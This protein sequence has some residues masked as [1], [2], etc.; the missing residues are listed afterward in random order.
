MSNK[1]NL[2]NNLKTSWTKFSAVQVI[3]VISNNEIEDYLIGKK[4]IDE[5]ILKSFLGIKDLKDPI[6]YY[7]KEI[8]K[9]PS[10]KK[11]FALL[12]AIFTHHAVIKEFAESSSNETFGG[13]LKIQEGVKQ[14]TNLRRA[15]IESG[16]SD[17]NNGRK[18]IVPYNFSAIY[19]VGGLGKL[20]KEVLKERLK[21]I[22]Y[23]NTENNSEFYSLAFELDFHKVLCLNK[24]QFKNW[25]EGDELVMKEIPKTVNLSQ[26]ENLK[27]TKALVVKQ[28]MNE[29]DK[30]AFDETKKRKKPAS[31]FLLLSI[32]AQ[33]LKK[34]SDVKRR[35]VKDK[36]ID[37]LGIQRKLT[38]ERSEEIS[39]YVKGGYPW[40]DLSPAKR[41]SGNFEDM[42]M[43]GWLPTAIVAN[44]IKPG[45]ITKNGTM[46]KEDAVIV[47]ENS[48][49]LASVVFPE[50]YF[51]SDWN[52]D[53]FPIEIIDG[54]HRL[55]SFENIEN[56]DGNFE[57]PVVAFYDLDVT[58]Q[59]YL[60][61]T[62]NIKPKRIN[63]SLAYDLY[64]LLRVQE[65]LE[66]TEDSSQ[67]YKETRAQ[68]LTE[69]LW[70]HPKSSWHNRINMLGDNKEGSITQ[71]AFLRSLTASF[72]KKWETNTN[73]IGGLFGAKINVNVEEVLEWSRTQ[74]AAFLLL[75]WSNLENAVKGT[76]RRWAKNIRDNFKKQFE[77]F[78]EDTDKDPALISNYSLLATDQGVRGVFQIANDICYVGITELKIKNIQ[79]DQYSFKEEEDV[80]LENISLAFDFLKTQPINDFLNELFKELMAFD[81]RTSSTIG[82]SDEEKRHQMVFR[83]SGGYKEIRKQLLE[84]L[85]KSSNQKIHSLSN[86]VWNFLNY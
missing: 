32:P 86:K 41:Q 3:D 35:D 61:Y 6:P 31:N 80:K 12:A 56:I 44:I 24:T 76:Q 20:F 79:W 5:P 46:K 49:G 83:G 22:G 69:I 9:Y 77:L 4:G 65:W 21:R 82:L 85:T 25:L 27:E 78:E 37:D 45:T 73:K 75:V 23:E 39:R 26:F 59:A 52:P 42:R 54:Q 30:V 8:Q 67:V 60:F 28:W 57:L 14:Y 40:S 50:N 63:Q 13:Q 18:K 84:I 53:C 17:A 66:K 72:L 51:T 55:L 68:E 11:I 48:D 70:M 10:E 43:P 33:V 62:I 38:S 58:W 2:I 15:L 7:W 1:Q 16:A 81:W 34:L 71:A 47:K 74:Q 64:P 19:K 29:W 36:R